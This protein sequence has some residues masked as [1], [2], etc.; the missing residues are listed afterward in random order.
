[1]IIRTSAFNLYTWRCEN[2]ASNADRSELIFNRVYNS[3]AF[4]KDGTISISTGKRYCLLTGPSNA[5][6]W[7]IERNEL[8]LS[9]DFSRA[10]EPGKKVILAGA[11]NPDGNSILLAFEDK[12]RLYSILFT[13]LK[14]TAE[15]GIKRCQNILYSHGGQLAACRYGK[16]PNSCVTIINMLRSVEICTFKIQS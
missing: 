12:V 4:S 16:T 7:S 1:M 15:F 3:S 14:L 11:I 10:E 6:L 9:T 2:L 5:T 13:K 8:V